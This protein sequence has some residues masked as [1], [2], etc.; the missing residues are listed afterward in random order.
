MR[1]PNSS[2]STDLLVSEWDSDTEDESGDEAEAEAEAAAES[3]EAEDDP[4]GPRWT[5][6]PSAPKAVREAAELSLSD[7]WGKEVIF[8]DLLPK[9]NSRVRGGL[10]PVRRLVTFFIGHWWCG[11]C[12][13]YALMSLAR[14]SKAV[15]ERE[16][17]RVVIISSGSW[18]AISKF[19]RRFNIPFPAYVDRSTQLYAALGMRTAFPNPFMEGGPNRPKYHRHGLARQMVTGMAVS[20]PHRGDADVAD[21]NE[22]D[23]NEVARQLYA[24][25]R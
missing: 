1:T 13:D 10:P 24:A 4:R 17:V 11:L 7:E 18:K 3:D 23:I 6:T 5:W 9:P 19:R 8:G 16:G 25:R 2:R 20:E 14:L 21:R 12:H 15:L 22:N